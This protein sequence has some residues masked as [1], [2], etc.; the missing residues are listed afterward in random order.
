MKLLK[1][2]FLYR[3]SKQENCRRGQISGNRRNMSRLCGCKYEHVNT[4]TICRGTHQLTVFLFIPQVLAL[5]NSNLRDRTAPHTRIMGAAG[6]SHMLCYTTNLPSNV[7]RH[8]SRVEKTL[9]SK[10]LP[11]GIKALAKQGPSFEVQ[12]PLQRQGPT[13]ANKLSG[14]L[15]RKPTQMQSPKVSAKS[16]SMVSGN[17]LV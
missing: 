1:L 2:S 12:S 16:A 13:T 11:D 8:P 9:A 10:S 7:K 17:G 6:A 14:R 4:V 3:G 5:G 15:A